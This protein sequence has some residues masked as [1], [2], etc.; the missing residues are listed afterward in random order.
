[1]ADNP[2][3]SAAPVEVPLRNAPLVR[4]LAQIRF[5]VTAAIQDLAAI[6][7]FQE[8]IRADYPI[9]RRESLQNV[10]LSSTGPTVQAEQVWRF[11]DVE[12]AWRVSL[13]PNFV[14]LETKSYT[15]RTDF[16]A[17]LGRVAG[18]LIGPLDPKVIERFG[19]RYINRIQGVHV[20][21]IADLVR[22][23]MRGIV[24]TAIQAETRFTLSD[25]VFDAPEEGAVLHARWGYIPP[26][27]TIDPDAM[28]PITVPS[29]VM[30]LDVYTEKGVK[31]FDAAE[32]TVRAEQ[33]ASRSYTFFRW[34]VTDRFLERFGGGDD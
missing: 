5:P 15:S 33:F 23:E 20:G 13:S 34:A 1:M 21:D 24:G 14:A 28:E 18:A 2:L 12:E 3:R 31:H 6:A 16:L 22:N 7:P 27:S 19:I 8:A 26:N 29:W 4:V 30:D 25:A 17:R 9:L 32:V 11:T 10:V